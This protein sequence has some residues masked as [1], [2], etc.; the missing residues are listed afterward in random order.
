MSKNI[1][2][3]DDDQF[4]L[5]FVSNLLTED[6]IIHKCS[7]IDAAKEHLSH[8]KVHLLIMDLNLKDEHG[9][10]LIKFLKSEKEFQNLPI[11]T[12][13]SEDCSTTKIETLEQGVNDFIVKPFLPKEL[14]LKV[15]NLLV[16][17]Y[18]DQNQNNKGKLL[19]INKVSLPTKKQFYFAAKRGFDIVA[20]STLLILLSPI[21]IL[22]AIAIRL[23]SPGPIFYTSKRIG[24]NYSEIPFFKF[25]SMLV[26]ADHLVEKLKDQNA[27]GETK[28]EVNKNDIPKGSDLIGDNGYKIGENHLKIEKQGAT[29]FKLENDPRVTKVGAI[30]RRTSID[31][32]PQLFNVFLGHMSLVG[33]R[34]L[35]V[36]EA[37]QLTQDFAVGR[38]SNSA[39]IT[40]LWQ[41]KKAS[42][43]F[44]TTEK[45][46]ELD[47]NYA[48]K[49]SLRR[50]LR[51]LYQ[52]P[53]AMLQKEE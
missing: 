39:G 17:K 53:F 7:T 11:I 3:L 45:R 48:N 41:V 18:P 6:Y 34:P 2:I 32:L 20:S 25:R 14:T 47:V 43:P 46:I 38:F 13:S 9:I 28:E 36:Y 51:L 12:L 21:F 19:K 50:D 29:F 49:Y 27:Y 35:P 23:E 33:N 15:K 8:Q 10:S 22:T 16:D 44:M 1:V 31:E 4:M 42:D 37:E 5:D 26:N 40:G 24:K 30:I 52:T